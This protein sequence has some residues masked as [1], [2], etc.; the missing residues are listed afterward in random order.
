MVKLSSPTMMCF[1][2]YSGFTGRS[3]LHVS[4]SPVA[5]RGLTDPN[6]SPNSGSV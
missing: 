3:D 1:S 6:F 5:D 4:I 2:T